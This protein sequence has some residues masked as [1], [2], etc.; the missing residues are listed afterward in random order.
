M[1]APHPTRLV[2]FYRE[3][4]GELGIAW[5]EPGAIHM[6]PV[7]EYLDA[8]LGKGRGKERDGYYEDL[9]FVRPEESPWPCPD[10]PDMTLKEWESAEGMSLLDSTAQFFGEKV[11]LRSEDEHRG[12][13][14]WI[15]TSAVPDRACDAPPLVVTG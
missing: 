9:G 10:K 13:A 2:D 7:E 12:V 6:E 5:T 11:R 4:D 8:R 1:S 3:T 15:L 14:A